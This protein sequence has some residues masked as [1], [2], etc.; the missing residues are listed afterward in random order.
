MTTLALSKTPS[1]NKVIYHLL[2]WALYVIFIFGAN[3]IADK[4]L[5]LSLTI[6]FLLPLCL[7]FYMAIFFLN[8]FRKKGPLGILAAFMV[9]F[10]IMASFGYLYIYVLLPPMGMILYGTDS[11]QHYLKSAILG[12]VQYFSYALLFFYVRE[13]F[14]KEKNL[15]KMEAEK[16]QKELENAKL[17]EQELQAQKEKLAMEFA[18]LRAQVNPHFLHNIL[19]A[20]CEQAM[21]YSEE[22]AANI[23]R[24]SRIMRYSLESIPLAGD[25]VPVEQ[26][27]EQ[28]KALIDFHHLRFADSKLIRYTVKGKATGQ[29]VPPLSLITVVENAFKHGELKDPDHPLT[30]EVTLKPGIVHFVCRNKKQKNNPVVISHSIGITN[31]QKRLDVAFRNQY[32]MQVNQDDVVYHFELTIKS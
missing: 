29:C 19:N 20:L 17:K 30:I 28:L 11:F 16:L 31:L 5:K 1:F 3:F 15:R 13:L 6:L 32:S 4:D 18:F 9:T 26:E 25:R 24:L 2:A 12:Y 21:D 10:M 22:L 8:R 23:S 27:L 7:T 14:R